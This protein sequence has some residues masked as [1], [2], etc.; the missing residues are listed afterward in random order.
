MLT[1]GQAARM[2]GTS[3]TTLTRA[4][5]AGRLSATRHDDGS[6]AID[7]AELTRA[8]SIDPAAPATG[9]A[10]GA[11]AHQATG[12]RDPGATTHDIELSARLAVMEA[13]LKGL[14]E[15]VSELRQ[16]RDQWQFQAERV[17]TLALAAPAAPS[18][19]RRRPWWRRRAG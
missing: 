18:S 17:T 2:T 3:K 6:Y 15:M 7:P 9:T 12:D 13:E 10:T 19:E 8:Y 5:K 11:A 1:L 16:S 14:K 4:I